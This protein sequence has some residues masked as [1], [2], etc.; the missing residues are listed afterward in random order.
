MISLTRLSGTTFLLNADLIERV[1]CTPDTVVTLVDGTK[2][3]VAESLDEVCDE[4]IDYRAAIVAR[5]ALPDASS[6]P[7]VRPTRHSRLSA[8]PP[9]GVT[10]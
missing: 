5:A 1:D 3:V 7:P 4:V 8:V 9:R 6:I 10:P 2:Y